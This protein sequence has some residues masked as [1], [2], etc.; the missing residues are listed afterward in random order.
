MESRSGKRWTNEEEQQLCDFVSKHPS[1][2]DV[3]WDAIA[4]T[5]KRTQNACRNRWTS[6]TRWTK[7]N[8]NA[9]PENESESSSDEP[10]SP[11]R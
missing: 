5:L 1:D 11:K 2:E 10:P 6:H 7:R 4:K 8:T 9:Q 3:D